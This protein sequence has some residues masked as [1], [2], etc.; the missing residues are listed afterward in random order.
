MKALRT[1][2]LEHLFAVHALRPVEMRGDF[3]GL[4]GLDRPDVVPSGQR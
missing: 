1:E 3:A 2:A 4:V